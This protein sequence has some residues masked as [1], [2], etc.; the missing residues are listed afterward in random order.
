MK[1]REYR[2]SDVSALARLFYETVHTVNAA[3][4]DQ[5]QLDAWA[6]G[7]VDLDV[8]NRSFLEHFT[9]VAEEG[10]EIV[11]FGDIDC[12]GYLDR[13][14]VHKDFQG[15]GIGSSCPEQL[16][17]NEEVLDHGLQE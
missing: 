3:D 6:D 13:L 11:G 5:E 16:Q 14:Y 4:Y 9:V 17:S 8:W 2:P 1:L 10:G 12:S 15:Q 7:H